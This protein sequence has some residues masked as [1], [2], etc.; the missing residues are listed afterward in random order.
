MNYEGTFEIGNL[1]SVSECVK[2]FKKCDTLNGLYIRDDYAK[3]E[4]KMEAWIKSCKKPRTYFLIFGTPGIGKSAFSAYYFLKLVKQRVNLS[5]T[6]LK[7]SIYYFTFDPTRN[8]YQITR[9]PIQDKMYY[10][11][12]MEKKL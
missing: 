10:V 3:L 11:Y 7:D 1:V 12:L 9:H 5:Y 8:K 4:A 6:P 2:L